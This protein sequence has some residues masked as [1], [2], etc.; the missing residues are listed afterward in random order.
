MPT[1]EQLQDEI[2]KIKARN[3]RVEADKAWE[4]SWTRRFVI[5]SLTYFVV[6]IFFMFAH[7]PKPFTNA[8]IPTL[9]FVLSTLSMPIIKKWWLNKK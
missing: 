6:V 2:N 4:N 5:L 9:G 3:A 7:L 1:T 8:T